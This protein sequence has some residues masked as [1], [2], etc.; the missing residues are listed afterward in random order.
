MLFLL[1]LGLLMSLEL[2]QIKIQHKPKQ[3][4]E[5]GLPIVIN[6]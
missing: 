4:Q 1:M 2:L 5:M 3:E 6:H